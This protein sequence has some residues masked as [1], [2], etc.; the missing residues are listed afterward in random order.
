MLKRWQYAAIVSEE[1]FVSAAV[2]NLGYAGFAFVSAY[3]RLAREEAAMQRL[4]PF[5][6]GVKV[7]S[8]IADGQTRMRLPGLR[9]EMDNAKRQLAIQVP[10]IAIEASWDAG[11]AWD[12]HWEIGEA[13]YDHTCK[14]MG[15]ASKGILTLKDRKRSLEG[16]A[17]LDHTE[18]RLA[19]TTTW[20]WAAGVGR[21]GN[22]L[23]AWNLRTGLDDPEERESAVWV[24]G[25]PSAPGPARIAPGSQWEV[26][27]G[28]LD[29]CF[30]PDGERCEDKDLWLVKSRYRQPWGRYSG[31]F[32]GVPLEGYGVVEDHWALW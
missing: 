9:I 20:R 17:L 26:S 23:V 15:V 25:V 29:L 4:V 5:A 12:S 32:E 2:V 24:D 28:A 10:G 13:G 6:L 11:E 3:D 8:G 1:A 27:A 22:R 7:A 16:H 19:R 18:G 30:D 21:A 14:L 31:T